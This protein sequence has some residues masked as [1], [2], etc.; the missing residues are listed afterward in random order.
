MLESDS[1]NAISAPESH[2]QP[3]EP[4]SLTIPEL[5]CR[6]D[7][8]CDQALAV[9]SCESSG[10]PAASDGGWNEGLFQISPKYHSWRLREG[11][12]LFDAEGNNPLP[13]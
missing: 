7:W 4:T 12:A 1:G 10:N 3:V 6:M 8:P 9:M 2:A 11:E 13:P 5:I